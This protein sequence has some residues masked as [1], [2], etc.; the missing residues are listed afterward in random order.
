M[1]PLMIGIIAGLA[2]LAIGSLITAWLMR[3]PGNPASPKVLKEELEA[4]REQ[5]ADHFAETASLV[6]RMTDSYK[7][8][9]DHLQGGAS[10]L[11]G[12]ERLRQKLADQSGETITLKRLGTTAAVGGQ[13]AAPGPDATNSERTAAGDQTAA[14]TAPEPKQQGSDESADNVEPRQPPA[15]HS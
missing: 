1:S 11:I 10:Q 2:G 8:V 12:E 6:N 4:Y 5:V 15:A 14:E 9:F 3:R 13:R 7:D